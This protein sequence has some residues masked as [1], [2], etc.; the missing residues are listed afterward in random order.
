MDEDQKIIKELDITQ[1]ETE[2]GN[3]KV[4]TGNNEAVSHLIYAGS[5]IMLCL[6][7]LQD[8][9]LQVPVAQGFEVR[10]SSNRTKPP[11][12]VRTCLKEGWE[13]VEVKDNESYEERLVL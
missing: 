11:N 10:N 1:D 8:Q 13:V 2:G 12:R 6:N 4:V 7:F 9:L 3:L 5:D